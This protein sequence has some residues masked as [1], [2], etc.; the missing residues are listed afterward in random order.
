MHSHGA[1]LDVLSCGSRSDPEPYL[2]LQQKGCG[3]MKTLSFDKYVQMLGHVSQM[4]Q[5]PLSSCMC[6]RSDKAD[7]TNMLGGAGPVASFA[8]PPVNPKIGLLGSSQG[9]GIPHLSL[10]IPELVG[11][12]ASPLHS[13]RSA[14]SATSMKSAFSTMHAA[15]L[16]SGN[17]NIH[18]RRTSAVGEPLA[19]FEDVFD[20][21]DLEM[22]Q[23]DGEDASLLRSNVSRQLHQHNSSEEPGAQLIGNMSRPNIYSEARLGGVLQNPAVIRFGQA[24]KSW[25]SKLK[26]KYAEY[27]ETNL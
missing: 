10:A 9:S 12:D 6:C 17:S 16:G 2:L 15:S 21:N 20:A 5:T 24:T 23:D 19:E 26:S 25:G 22:G 27:R 4:R 18:S 8:G 7:T 14:D 13:A 11:V 1:W 3:D